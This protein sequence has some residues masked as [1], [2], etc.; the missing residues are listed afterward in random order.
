MG[1]LENKILELSRKK[2]CSIGVVIREPNDEIRAS[3]ERIKDEIDVLIVG[4][5]VNN[6]ETIGTQQNHEEKLIDL[7][8]NNKVDGII[9]GQTEYYDLISC[10]CRKL[11]KKYIETVTPAV[12]KDFHGRV[13]AMP[14]VN[15]FEGHL[16]S[17]KIYRAE[18]TSRWLQKW[19]I[20][21]VVA[22]MTA[23]AS[24]PAGQ[25]VIIDQIHEQGEAVVEGL[26]RKGINAEL[27][28]NRL[29]DAIENVGNIIVPVNGIIGH[30]I[31]RSVCHLGGGKPI[32]GPILGYDLII[33][34]QTK[35]ESD[36]V[37]HLRFAA[38]WANLD[39]Q[40]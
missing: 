31:Y 22:V 9:R 18:L 27:C 40:N 37:P 32:C 39:S 2:R 17:D 10:L 29:E 1:S 12:I 20:E 38:A 13:F 16:V 25:E 4:T 5:Q 19:D 15:E 36:L 34:D 3:L 11:N 28:N 8:I 6:F 23:Q 7:L 30:Q 33:C 26:R 14:L 24:F 21:T 35:R